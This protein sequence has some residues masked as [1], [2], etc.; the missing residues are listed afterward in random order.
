M[1]ILAAYRRVL[2]NAALARLLFGEF[3]SSIG[4]WLYLVALLVLIWNETQDA[5]TLGIIGAARIVP[6]ILLS[7]PAGIVADRFDRRLVLLITDI[8]RGVLMLVIAA[9][10]ALNAPIVVIVGLAITATC[11]SAFFSPAIGAYLPSLVRDES[12][13]G[14]ANSAWASLDNLAF[15]LGPTFA[16]ILL[17][18][19]SLPLAFVLNS[20]TFFFVAAVLWRLPSR[21]PKPGAEDEPTATAEAKTGLWDVLRPIQRPLIGLN[22][23]NVVVGFVWGGLGVVTVIISVQVFNVDEATGTGLLNSAIGVGGLVGALF[24]AALVLRRRQGPPLVIGA[25]CLGVGLAALGQA[26]AFWL[27]LVAMAFASAGALLVEIVTTTL[28]QRIV[29][30]DVRGRTLGLVNTAYVIFYA[31]GAF[32]IPILAYGQAGLVLLA[33]GVAI[34]VAGVLSLVLLGAYA[35][36]APAADDVRR[37]IADVSLFAGLPPARLET[38]MRR[39]TVRTV[40]KGEV[41]IRQGDQADFFYVIADGRV[42]VTQAEASGKVNLLR[43]MGVG[44]FFGEIGLLSRVPRT[45]T[46]TAL[47]ETTLVALDG[48]AFLELVESGPG[49]TYTLLDLHRG[50]V[51]PG[52]EA[53]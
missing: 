2:G 35:I 18:I 52:V 19:G 53:A 42:E 3:V 24:A 7:V 21:R 31:A 43:Q 37:R 47:R 34:A 45:A 17:S 8:V 20:F 10:V 38:A 9:A 33:G 44:E 48:P 41:I 29:P 14:P 6:Y 26:P 46:V 49:L 16:A 13:L 15:F 36:Q 23:L 25:I 51:S 27:A 40:P 1:A 22:L 12:E 32:V 4:D 39:A 30:D 11:F 28:L 50:A 5:L